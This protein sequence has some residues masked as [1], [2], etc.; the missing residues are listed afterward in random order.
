MDQ[1]IRCT[2]DLAALSAPEL[3]SLHGRVADMLR[4][5]GV[6]RSSNNPTGDLAEH[7]FCKA[8]GWQQENN[9]KAQFDAVAPNGDKYQ[10]KGRRVTRHNKSRQLG[11]HPRIS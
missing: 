1:I 5:R 8:F 10:I 9:S 11:C 6:T 4:E 7:L 3:L 2:I